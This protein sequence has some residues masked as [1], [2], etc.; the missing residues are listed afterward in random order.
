[1]KTPPLFPAQRLWRI[2][3]VIGAALLLALLALGRNH[4]FHL[5]S[6]VSCALKGLTGLPC[7]LCG[8]TRAAEALLRGDVALALHLNALAIPAVALCL[9]VAAVLL[10]EGV[11]GRAVTNWSALFSRLGPFLPILLL[12][13]FLW[14]IPQLAGALRGTKPELLDLRNPLARTLHEKFR[15]PG[16]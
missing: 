9:A 7:P 13:L 3:V 6:P 12:L 14:W 11:R 16:P 10:W 2:G 15:A 5:T 1:M 8:G 4:G